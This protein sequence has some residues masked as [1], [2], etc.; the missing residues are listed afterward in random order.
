MRW[1]KNLFF[2]T[3]KILSAVI[4]T[5]LACGL[6][7]ALYISVA[8]YFNITTLLPFLL[9][10]GL[11]LLIYAI[12]Q[13]PI[14][15]YI[16]THELVHVIWVLIFGGKVKDFRMGKRGGS[17]KVSKTNFIIELAP[18]LFPLYCIISILVYFMAGLF[19]DV[20]PYWKVMSFVVGFFWA[21]HFTIT[22]YV[23]TKEQ[24]DFRGPGVVLSLVIVYIFNVI[25]L[26]LIICF[27]SDSVSF[28]TYA[29]NSIDKALICYKALYST[30]YK[31]WMESIKWLENIKQC[32][33]LAG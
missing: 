31:I 6:S 16:F 4:L 3:L 21:F 23:L 20:K 32:F 8:Q 1:L 12:L 7:A 24:T 10:F 26:A 11:Y 17:V 15:T 5:P 27:L 22:A 18:Y 25:I 2:S 33:W 28:K 29:V 30:C 19:I 14:R 13:Q 9:G